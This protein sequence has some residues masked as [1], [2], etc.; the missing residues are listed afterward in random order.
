MNFKDKITSNF[1]L[2]VAMA[3]VLLAHSIPG[4]FDGGVIVFGEHYLNKAGFD[5][6]GV[7]LAWLIKFSHVLAAVGLVLNRYVNL[8]SLISMV[9]LIAGI[10]MIHLPNGWFVVGGGANGIEYNF[11]LIIILLSFIMDNEKVK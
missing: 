2:R 10:F 5:P 1:L 8:A 4:M 3:I 6:F 7:P 11:I 9:I